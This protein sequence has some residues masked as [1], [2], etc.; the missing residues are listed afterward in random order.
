MELPPPSSQNQRAAESK[1]RVEL[2]QLHDMRSP[3]TQF[4]NL[5]QSQEITKPLSPG[6]EANRLE[7][8]KA[9]VDEACALATKNA[10]QREYFSGAFLATLP[11]TLGGWTSKEERKK[12]PEQMVQVQA[13]SHLWVGLVALHNGETEIDS[14]GTKEKF[15]VVVDAYYHRRIIPEQITVQSSVSEAQRPHWVFFETIRPF[16]WPA[17]GE[18]RIGE[19]LFRTIPT[20]GTQPSGATSNG[21]A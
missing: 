10:E 1:A 3:V 15:H 7:E 17:P 18:S 5:L 13:L 12:E 21:R 11:A 9:K 20:V 2:Q 16:V 4:I 19:I 6:R 8:I 14:K